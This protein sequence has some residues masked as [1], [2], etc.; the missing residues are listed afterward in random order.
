[1]ISESSLSETARSWNA[2]LLRWVE[3]RLLPQV[4]S[5][6]ARMHR[7][8]LAAAVLLLLSVAYRL[9]SYDAYADGTWSRHLGAAVSGVALSVLVW[10]LLRLRRSGVSAIPAV[11]ALLVLFAGDAVHLLRL[12]H[13]LARSGSWVVIDERSYTPTLDPH[14]WSVRTSGDGQVQV[15]GN[16]LTV[17]NSPLSSAQAEVY[18]HEPIQK[19]GW[20]GWRQ[21]SLLPVAYDDWLIRSVTWTATASVAQSFYVVLEVPAY[22]LVVEAVPGGLHLTSPDPN[23]SAEAT[24]KDLELPQLG[25]GAGHKWRINLSPVVIALYLDGQT[26]WDAPAKAKTALGP[27]RFGDARTD[28]QHGGQITLSNVRYTWNRRPQ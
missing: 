17:A 14:F 13:P 19:A 22:G 6:R 12:T 2:G 28:T 5:L 15:Q 21:G 3:R 4:R 8:D 11:A 10:L 23:G 7:V 18:L 1:M 26:I 20:Y 24:S 25:D 9:A 16:Q 27:V